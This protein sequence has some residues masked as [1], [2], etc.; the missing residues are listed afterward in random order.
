MTSTILPF[1][2]NNNFSNKAMAQEM[3]YYDNE[4]YE[5]YNSDIKYNSDDEI[6]SN[7]QDE[8]HHRWA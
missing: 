6:Y 4:E 2:N 1:T 3:G 8:Q 5:D 7:Y